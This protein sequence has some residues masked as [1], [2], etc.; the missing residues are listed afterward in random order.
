MR[1]FCWESLVN[2]KR[3]VARDDAPKRILAGGTAVLISIG[4]DRD[5]R[6]T[7]DAGAVV[8]RRG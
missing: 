7:K 5:Y 8:L 3:S 2:L 6:P 4:T 1:R